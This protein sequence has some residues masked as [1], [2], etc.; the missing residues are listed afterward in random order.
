VPEY[1]ASVFVS[2][3]HEDKPRVRK[4][5]AYLKE[6]GFRIWLDEDDLRIGDSL[7]DGIFRAID[8]I[9][10]VLALNSANS[11]DSCWCRKEWSFAVNVEIRRG[12]VVVLPVRMDHTPMPLLFEDK[13]HLDIRSMNPRQAADRITCRPRRCRSAA[14]ARRPAPADRER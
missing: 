8:Q 3:A 6:S 4:I 11:V 7:P 1:V 12:V 10:F 9:D 14:R 2:H 5:C 13:V